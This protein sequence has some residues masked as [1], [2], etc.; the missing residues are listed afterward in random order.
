VWHAILADIPGSDRG[1][2]QLGR[3][4][5]S[6]FPLCVI[7]GIAVAVVWGTRR[8]R[9]R[10]GP[11]HVVLQL[12]A[13]TIVF[14]VLGGRLDHVL[15]DWP[16]YFGAGG[17]PLSALRLWDGGLGI[18][19][20]IALG[21]LGAYLGCARRMPFAVLAD[22]LAPTLAV[23]QALGR[24]GDW[25]NQELYG[26]PT[27]LPWAMPIYARYIQ[28]TGITDL[29]DGVA[30]GP[31]LQMVH[32]T[33]LYELLWDLLVAAVVVWVDRRH[34][35]GRGRAFAVY[36][37]G[38]AAG[39]FWIEQLR[40]D[41]TVRLLGEVR[42]NV[43]IAFLVFLGAGAYLLA[44]RGPREV[45]KVWVE[46]GPSQ[47]L[48][49]AAGN[50]DR[51][52]QLFERVCDLR[53]NEI[54][55]DTET[56][57]VTFA[58]LD[59]QANQLARYLL[60][61]GAEPGDR[62]GL[63]FDQPLASYS[64][65]LA[66]LKIGATYVPLDVGF[67]ADRIGYVF[68]D[69]QVRTL[70]TCAS[71]R[72]RVKDFDEMCQDHDVAVL[73][74]NDMPG[75]A[76]YGTGRLVE[77][78]RGHQTEELAYIIYTSGSTGRPK[79]VAVEHSS[80]CTFVSV[81]AG[82]YGIRPGDRM[83]QG[84]TIAFDFSVEEI[85]VP[86]LAGA[87]LVPK[88]A[89]VTLV[90]AE[91]HEF[92]SRRRVSA[93]CCV[94]TLLAT[95]EE[96]LPNLRFLLVSGEACP[97]NLIATWYR[98][99]RRF[100]NVYGPTE[101]T[102]TAT[103]TAVHPGT[104]V[105]IGKPLPGYAA[106]ILDPDNPQ[107]A[108]PRGEVGEVAI[109]GVGLARGYI[110]R[111][112]Q[113]AA[114]F[115]PDFLS[116]PQNPSNRLYRTGDMG[117]I[118]PDGDIEYLGRIDFQIKLRGYRIELTEIESV[119]LAA[120]GVAAAVVDTYEPVPGAVELVGYYTARA[121]SP[122]PDPDVLR[123]LLAEQLPA[124]MVPAYLEHLEVIPMTSSDKADRKNLPAPT[125]PRL[126]AANNGH[127]DH[128]A[129]TETERLLTEL[130]SPI[131]GLEPSSIPVTADIFDDLGITSLLV[132][133]F[134]AAARAHPRLATVSARD[135]Y[136]HRT[137][138]GLATHLDVAPP[139]PSVLDETPN[140]L[141]IGEP[142]TSRAEAA[143][144]TP[145]TGS[146]NLAYYL[147]GAAQLVLLGVGIFLNALLIDRG[148]SWAT[149]SPDT[150]DVIERSAGFSAVA[151]LALCLAPVLLKWLLIG[152]FTAGRIPL[153]SV[154]YLRFWL[155][156]T[157][158]MTSPMRLFAGTPLFT[159]YL[160]LL[161]A[162]IG[163]DVALLTVI[164]P[165]VTDMITIGDRTL[166]R[167][168][169]MLLGYRAVP[170]AI[171][172]GPV[173]V[174]ADCRVG[175]N[176]V[177]EIN[178]N[179]SDGAVLGHS[180]SL[181]PHQSVPA[182]RTWHG[183]PASP[184]GTR[185]SE[186]S[187]MPGTRRRAT[188]Q[189]ITQMAVVVAA[190][191][192]FSAATTVLLNRDD[193]LWAVL[194]PDDSL[195]SSPDFCEALVFTAIAV[196]LGALAVS[197]LAMITLPKLLRWVITPGTVYPLYG[198]HHSVQRL[199]TL[200]TNSTYLMLLLGDSSFIVY[201][202][203]AVGYRLK[204][205]EQTG[206]NFGT[207][208]RHDNPF[209]TTVGAG[210]LISDGLVV[211]NANYS[212]T[213]FS[214]APVSIGKSTFIGND[215]AYPSDAKIGDNCLIATK[216]MVP[217]D[218]PVREG[219]GLLGSPSFEIPRL[220]T[221]PGANLSLPTTEEERREP[222]AAKNRHNLTTMGLAVGARA[223]RLIIRLLPLAVA[224]NLWPEFG[225]MATTLGL[226]GALIAPPI[227]SAL[228]ERAV[229]GFQPLKPQLCTMYDLP[230]WQQ[231]RLWK[232]YIRPVLPGTPFITWLSRLAGLDIGRRVYD[233]G[234][235]VPEKTLVHIG[236]DSV[237]NAGS[238]IQCHSME[239][240]YFQS[241]STT[242]ARS[243][244]VGVKAFVHYGTNLA[245]HTVIAA[246]SFLLKGEHTAP[247]DYWEGNPAQAGHHAHLARTAHVN[248][249][250]AFSTHRRRRPIGR[251]EHEL[252]ERPRDSVSP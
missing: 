11:R 30:E 70:L 104:P 216:A 85:W 129:S 165:I 190:T 39:R 188:I 243:V 228:L 177:L 114:A 168:G 133:K 137:L 161:G 240:G 164:P 100:L 218:G 223:L 69:A 237:L 184:T 123:A 91:L 81:A 118:T 224:V 145:D 202:L 197:V 191:S 178:T 80:I 152:R 61:S 27:S 207:Q 86:W 174:G 4:R 67:P 241:D 10:G 166:V 220:S 49:R 246:D 66:V 233:D 21:A 40:A 193:S 45:L 26:L 217:I 57:R 183:S 19:G 156:K 113:T 185:Y 48:V 1:V 124:Y 150:A 120:P 15:S 101:A 13:L 96:D 231:E 136:T 33:F 180:S 182:G 20:A 77:A 55:V 44:V 130:M 46:G 147:T 90:G 170:G 52:H 213:S 53:P 230:F 138:E 23:A 72:E 7:A 221:P 140:K 142:H 206:S 252:L 215:V 117:R 210:T 93:L 88:P 38:Y 160:R 171:E 194:T 28:G 115:I 149:A 153:W 79:G 73:D 144:S 251:D 47:Q 14:G 107:S 76:G 158:I 2:W 83:Y 244:T 239:N 17:D 245:D 25:F 119:L 186:P 249:I 32:P 219:V 94:P 176:S 242:L 112:E 238:V 116:I 78:G 74:V 18:W 37:A 64:A 106:V 132:A 167:P 201:F 42:L 225:V 24:I 211:M 35:L 248:Q 105:T 68:D 235:I 250:A 103:W 135:I 200:L 126:A 84:M 139:L 199:V 222:L 102:V 157:L 212:N 58:E 148:Y 63:L 198:I 155:V 109:A 204:P 36:V 122:E 247:H 3:I 65:M 203:Q 29:R 31:P 8:V 169:A 51:L 12:S 196:T 99:E 71:A 151:F 175:Q 92:L 9:Q 6:A 50:V 226:A 111:P 172:I 195:W 54:A 60:A 229:L 143:D 43:L 187:G 82:V 98:P 62:V 127:N 159:F 110:N 16:V 141:V 59:G 121:D 236:D 154:A 87:T 34:Q 205:V 146:S 162:N 208:L 189:G 75:L 95:L 179:L 234:C 214:V 108:V 181:Q 56:V 227:Y 173:R 134:S 5:L 128:P 131:L 163:R 209:L 41:P 232:F 22:A 192:A 97:E 89:G 125:G